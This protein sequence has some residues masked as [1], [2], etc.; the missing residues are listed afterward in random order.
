MSTILRVTLLLL[1]LGSGAAFAGFDGQ[2]LEAVQQGRVD[3]VKR[4]LSI[5]A[6]A[7]AADP[8]KRT[9]LIL[10]SRKG[11]AGIVK[12]LVEHYADVNARTH[13]Q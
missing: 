13:L 10:A 6:D 5:G 2:L 12:L 9:A 1:L 3:E 8:F 11:Y 4:L 7:N